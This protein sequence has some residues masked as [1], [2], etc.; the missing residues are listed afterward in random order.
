MRPSWIVPALLGLILVTYVAIWPGVTG[1]MHT[2]LIAWY[3]TII[4]KGRLG[5]FAEPFSNYTPPYL[6]LLSAVTLFDGLLP[7]IALIKAVSLAGTVAMAA[8]VAQLV[9]AFAPDDRQLAW[10]AALAAMALPTVALNGPGWGQCDAI[11]A[12]ACVMAVAHSAR[13]RTLAMLV[14]AGIAFAIKAQAAFIAPFVIARLIHDRGPLWYW[15]VP[16][17]AF[18]AMMVPAWLLGWPAEHLAT[19]YL[20]QSEYAPHSLGNA[21]NLWAF[22]AAVAGGSDMTDLVRVMALIAAASAAAAYIWHFCTRALPGSQLV[23]AALLSALVMPWLLPQM[24][25]RFFFLAD[26][27]ALALAVIVRSRCAVWIAILVESASLLAMIGVLADAAAMSAVGG[28]LNLAAICLCWR[29]LCGDQAGEN[30]PA[31]SSSNCSSPSEIA[32]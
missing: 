18:A 10:I 5:A 14:W 16:A 21:P 13:G 19:I 12:G 32:K 4:A 7:K 26:I 24:H 27:L 6:Y 17:V 11:W 22:V 3:D 25:E 30:V 31:A 8:A 20:R 1:D 29:E 9:R 2:W 28:V 23:T 15:A